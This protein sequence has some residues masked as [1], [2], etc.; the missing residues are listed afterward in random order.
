MAE[1]PGILRIGDRS[2]FRVPFWIRPELYHWLSSFG[3]VIKRPE[4]FAEIN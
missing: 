3:T 1:A 4:E 2:A